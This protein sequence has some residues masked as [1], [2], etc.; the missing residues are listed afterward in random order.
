MVHALFADQNHRIYDH[1]ELELAGQ[2]G[3]HWVPLSEEDLVPLPGG[4]KLFVLPGRTAV[5]WDGGAQRF[6]PLSVGEM[7]GPVKSGPPLAVAAFLP[8]GYTRLHLPAVALSANSPA[9]PLWT[10]TALGWTEQGFAASALRIDPM[11][12]SEAV[13]YDDR[14]LV[15]KIASRLQKDPANRL[16]H[17]LKHCAVAYHCFAAKNL[18]LQRWEAPLPTSPACNAQCVGCLSY[19]D[20]DG[21]EAS[22]ERIDFVPSVSELVAVA[23]PHLNAVPRA[24]VSFGQGCEGEP[25]LQTDLLVRV[26]GQLRKE[27][28]RGTIHLNTNGFDPEAVMRL[29]RAGL[30]SIRISLNSARETSYLS[31]YRPRHYRFR[32]V[33]ASIGRARDAGLYTAVNLLVFPGITDQEEEVTA[34]MELIRRVQPDMLHMRNLSIDPEVYLRLYPATD[35]PGMGVRRL[36]HLLRREFPELELGYF[37]RPKELFGRKLIAELNL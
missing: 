14:D 27:T 25:L 32:D 7:A 19:Q 3:R 6:W 11:D 4:T 24:I 37:N 23:L 15:E 5:G 13:H 1:P 12:H 10:Y 20:G 30:D 22:H 26:V 9:L 2:S 16:L 34:L 31:Y 33:I 21:C 28:D 18:F 8:A 17:H 35:T 29:A 36:T